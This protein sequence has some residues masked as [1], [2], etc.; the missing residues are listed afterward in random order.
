MIYVVERMT[1]KIVNRCDAW[2]LGG[3]PRMCKWASDA[4]Y[5]T[6]TQEITFGGDMIIWVE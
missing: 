4:G 3:V 6:M 2:E 5:S 1:Q